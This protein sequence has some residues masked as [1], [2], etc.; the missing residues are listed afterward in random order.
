MSVT[1][2]PY[3]PPEAKG[4]VHLGPGDICPHCTQRLK[5]TKIRF[6]LSRQKLICS[7]CK[8]PL[9]YRFKSLVVSLVQLVLLFFTFIYVPISFRIALDN[10]LLLVIP[11]L[12]LLVLIF[13][14]GNY[15]IKAI[16]IKYCS[17]RHLK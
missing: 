12:V 11:A 9:D 15:V 16:L 14:G 2:D 17:I 10:S 3:H 7:N 6:G 5:P 8:S 13:L 4:E 1:T